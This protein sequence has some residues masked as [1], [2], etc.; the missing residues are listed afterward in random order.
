M[1][2]EWARDLARLD[3]VQTRKRLADLIW[4][5]NSVAG[6]LERLQGEGLRDHVSIT[7]LRLEKVAKE[8]ITRL[9]G[10]LAE[11][12]SGPPAG[13]GS[14]AAAAHPIVT[15]PYDA[16]AAARARA[17]AKAA[18]EAKPAPTPAAPTRPQMPERGAR[19]PRLIPGR[20]S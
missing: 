16:F 12:R 8:E 7:K 19:L 9:S 18:G 10:F 15:P 11:Y 6:G 17:E 3:P 13:A 14:A 5:C 20:P 4:E 1:V 2:D